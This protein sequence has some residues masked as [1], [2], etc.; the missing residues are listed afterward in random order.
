MV[1]LLDPQRR[2]P[3]I[4]AT[5]LAGAALLSTSTRDI[6]APILDFGAGGL[7]VQLAIAAYLFIVAYWLSRNEL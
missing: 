7:N 2:I 3:A 4:V 6:I 5:A 1:L